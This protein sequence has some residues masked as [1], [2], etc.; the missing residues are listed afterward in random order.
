M[1]LQ[2]LGHPSPIG[3][4]RLASAEAAQSRTGSKPYEA[5][6]YS[7]GKGERKQRGGLNA[8]LRQAHGRMDRARAP[9]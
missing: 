3:Y 4:V 9:A 8:V 7:A 6:H 2:P 1:R 5:R